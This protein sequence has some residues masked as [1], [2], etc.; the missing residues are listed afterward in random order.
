[1]ARKR[2]AD[3]RK[4]QR[5]LAS[6]CPRFEELELDRHLQLISVAK[7]IERL[8][9]EKV[10]IILHPVE[11]SRLRGFRPAVLINQSIR[12]FAGNQREPMRLLENFVFYEAGLPPLRERFVIAHELGHI[13]LHHR[14]LARK[15]KAQR[16]G[17]MT[18]PGAKHPLAYSV[19]FTPTQEMEADLFAVCLSEQRQAP[20][21]RPPLV[22]PCIRFMQGLTRQEATDGKWFQSG[23]TDLLPLR[24]MKCEAKSCPLL[25]TA[26]SQGKHRAHMAP[27]MAP[28]AGE[29]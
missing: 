13:L 15:R 22:E 28:P 11:S 17:P 23:L 5:L 24:P 25:A 18:L 10:K 19:K 16:Y 8:L 29:S 3:S 26:M 27:H 9:G 21:P 7:A 2:L 20:A 14:A 1:M 6:V 4:Y 12:A